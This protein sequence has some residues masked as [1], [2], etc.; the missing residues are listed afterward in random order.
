MILRLL[1]EKFARFFVYG[2]EKIYKRI[3]FVQ[4]IRDRGESMREMQWLILIKD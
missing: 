2:S 4:G 1:S 3:A